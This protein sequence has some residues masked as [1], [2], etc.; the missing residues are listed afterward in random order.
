MTTLIH[1]VKKKDES[2]MKKISRTILKLCEFSK[3]KRY[4]LAKMKT[5]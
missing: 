5:T 2:D 4:N 3:D 1:F